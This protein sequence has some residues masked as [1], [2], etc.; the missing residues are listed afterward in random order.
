MISY[1]A[2]DFNLQYQQATRL[3]TVWFVEI[4]EEV[5]TDNEI[6]NKYGVTTIQKVISEGLFSRKVEPNK[7]WTELQTNF[8]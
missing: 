8:K 7:E 3:M 2:N 5:T 1:T 6:I 4:F